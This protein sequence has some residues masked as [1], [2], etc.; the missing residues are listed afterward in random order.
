MTQFSY[1]QDYAE[2]SKFYQLDKLTRLSEQTASEAATKARGAN[3]TEYKYTL[4][5]YYINPDNGYAGY[6][7]QEDGTNNIVVV[8]AGSANVD[9]SSFETPSQVYDFYNDWIKTNIGGLGT[10]TIPSQ[11]ESADFFMTKMNNYCKSNNL[12]LSS[13]G[14]SLGGSLNQGLGMLDKYKD[15]EFTNYNPFG[16][17]HLSNKLV[18]KGYQL[19]NNYSNITNLIAQNEPLSKL[20][21]QAGNVYIA[22][23]GD[24]GNLMENHYVDV[25]IVEKR[26][27]TKVDQPNNIESW[28][29]N[30]VNNVTD[31]TISAINTAKALT[32]FDV[33][34]SFTVNIDANLNTAQKIALLDSYPDVGIPVGKIVAGNGSISIKSSLELENFAGKFNMTLEQLRSANLWIETTTSANGKYTYIEDTQQIYIP[35]NVLR[36]GVS[37]DESF[38]T[39]RDIYTGEKSPSD[40]IDY[41]IP[42]DSEFY[43]PQGG[44]SQEITYQYTQA[45]IVD[46]VTQL[47]QAIAI[48]NAMTGNASLLYFMRPDLFPQITEVLSA[49][50]TVMHLPQQNYVQSGNFANTIFDLFASLNTHAKIRFNNP[51]SLDLDGD[52]IETMGLTNSNI[53]F[54]NDNDGFKEKTGWLKGDDGLLVI[55]KNNNGKIDNQSELF[56]SDTTKGFEDLRVYDT[57]NDGVIDANDAQFNDL[58]VWQD[59]NEN[60]ITDEGELFSLADKGITSINLNY[61]KIDIIQNGNKIAEESTYTKSDGT[62]GGIYDVLFAY[63]GMKSIYGGEY[64]LS[65]DTL[66]LPWLRGYGNVMD[67]QLAASQNNEL[68]EL[69]ENMSN[70]TSAAEIFNNFDELLAK[71]TG[72][73]A[74]KTEMQGAVSKQYIQVLQK[75]LGIN[76]TEEIADNVKIN[77]IAAYEQIKNKAFVEFIAQTSI[78]DE[79]EINFD[80]KDNTLVYNDNTYQKIVENLTDSDN[81]IV[82]Y[83][84]SKELAMTNSLDVNKLV[85]IITDLGYGAS[86]I[87]YINS[88]LQFTLDGE[89][90]YNEPQLPMYV[91]GTDGNDTI[92]GANSADIIYGMDGDDL[93]NGSG[94]D[95]FLHGGLGNDLL[96]GGEGNDTLVGGE[97]DDTL[98][99]GG[100]DDTYI[101]EQGND[102]I[103][104][105]SWVVVRRQ[106]WYQEGAFPFNFWKSRWVESKTLADGGNDTIIFDKNIDPSEVAFTRSGNDLII[107]KSS[108][109]N[110]TIKNWYTSEEQRV[111]NFVFSKNGLSFKAEHLLNL[112]TSDNSSTIYADALS[113]LIITSGDNKNTT[114]NPGKGNDVIIDKNTNTT[115]KININDGYKTILDC[116]G[117]DTV[118][119]GEGIRKENMKDS[120]NGLDLVITHEGSDN[121]LQ[122]LN[123]FSNNNNRI[124]LFKFADGSTLTYYQLLQGLSSDIPSDNDDIIVGDPTQNGVEINAQ[125]GND[126]IIGTEGN[127][128][129]D[130]GSGRDIMQGGE[131]DDIYYI[132][133]LYDKVIE[134][135]N[136]GHDT[137][138]SSISHTLDDNVEDL[139]LIGNKSIYGYGNSLDNKIIG[140]N[141]NNILYGA[142]GNDTLI[143]GLG[144]D[145]YYMVDSND[146][147]IEESN[148]GTDTIIS[149][150]SYT[151]GENIENLILSSSGG[152]VGS[153]I[154]GTGNELDNYIEGIA[155]KSN[156]LYGGDGNDTLHGGYYD[157]VIDEPDHPGV[158]T[159]SDSDIDV[160]TDIDSD[161]D[162]DIDTDPDNPPYVEPDTDDDFN[163]GLDFPWLNS[164]NLSSNDIEID[165]PDHP[166]VDTDSDSDTDA[167]TD[168]DVDTDIDT[169][170]DT[171]MDTDSGNQSIRGILSGG[172][173]DDTYV[174]AEGCKDT[175]IRETS[176]EDTILLAE[177]RNNNNVGFYQNNNDLI[178][179]YGITHNYG[180]IIVENYFL[181]NNNKIE[182]IQ[183]SNNE[184]LESSEIDRIIQDINAYAAENGMQ[185]SSAN[186][187]TKNDEL[188]QLVTSGWQS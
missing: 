77:Y 13:I 46:K 54:D 70:M 187:I 183:L 19:S 115:Y 150:G 118:E 170:I 126:L 174:F 15:I 31:C 85:G 40:L 171:D 98:E 2:L 151:L 125:G 36:G 93:L 51:L 163:I 80:Y 167:D 64:K 68:L 65:I 110:L 106:E 74:N 89:L 52:G 158:D 188:M 169:D 137:I 144:D 95:D 139:V 121:T 128:T 130:G 142:E 159:D 160:D 25:H 34:I 79:F 24:T 57:N 166:G 146:T 26:D 86:L 88:G 175:I 9:W 82:S 30:T 116:K 66:E 55:D 152:N 172:N 29:K 114:I 91:I 11:F 76:I 134:E 147:I 99:G 185:I 81:F 123:W 182:K 119:F 22:T 4:V 62:T 14:Q 180:K 1:S 23:T 90:H 61:N 3:S 83:M 157:I 58:K 87:S 140:N 122:I 100:G 131:G 173:G 104:D 12:E 71:W 92:E 78:A 109:N 73:S 143:G 177:T 96:I 127:D 69:I 168:T 17:K 149:N 56:G 138:Y 27:Y 21:E 155:N 154:I 161:T 49:M 67:L 141:K 120:R 186:D 47:T 39:V 32:A 113:N 20:F 44:E 84:L 35:E 97:G 37:Y 18:E 6:A 132:D 43:V 136:E 108:G 135:A 60:G 16:M 72:S 41:E 153:K 48:V 184:Y 8:H 103:L 53:Y 176:G 10:G 156:I 59:A 94:G 33:K 181:D 129:I 101:Y 42:E 102:T 145:T 133:N 28:I 165:E 5:D 105:E 124:E 107:E 164:N 75:F 111:E 7:F 63:D 162:T 179:N 148:G 112:R 50:S 45:P 117:D 38:E 178:I